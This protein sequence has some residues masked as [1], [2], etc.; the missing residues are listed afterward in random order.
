MTREHTN[1]WWIEVSMCFHLTLSGFLGGLARDVHMEDS[2]R[3][4]THCSRAL[5]WT[6][7]NSWQHV[8]SW[9][10]TFDYYG[11]YGR[12]VLVKLKKIVYIFIGSTGFSGC[13]FWA[14]L[15]AF[16]QVAKDIQRFLCS[17]VC[18]QNY[19]YGYSRKFRSPRCR[20]IEKLTP[21]P[22]PGVQT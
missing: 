15:S 19:L 16:C 13:T 2:W 17:Q 12:A 1:Y 5:R 8:F 6:Q 21:P 20:I 14:C 7:T 11:A 18:Q 9:S 3:T 4:A 10:A 22:P